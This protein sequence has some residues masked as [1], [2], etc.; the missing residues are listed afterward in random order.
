MRFKEGD[1]VFYGDSPAKIMKVLENSKRYRVK[2]EWNGKTGSMVDEDQVHE[3]LKEYHKHY[4]IFAKERIKCAIKR[5]EDTKVL[6]EKKII[7]SEN[8]LQQNNVNVSKNEM[9]EN[10]K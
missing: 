5:A 2:T 4:I 9:K 6:F 10:G 7:E 8:Y 3:S 1:E